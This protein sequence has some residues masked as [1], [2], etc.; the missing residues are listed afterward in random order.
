M[1][2]LKNVGKYQKKVTSN[3]RDVFQEKSAIYFKEVMAMIMSTTI[4][5]VVR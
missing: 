2:S 3:F 1:G 4:L 5:V